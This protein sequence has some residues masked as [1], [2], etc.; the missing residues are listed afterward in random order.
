MAVLKWCQDT[1]IDWHYIAPRK[2]M[3]NAFVESFNG[4]FRD[5]LFERNPFLIAGRSPRENHRMEGRLQPH[6]TALIP[7]QPH[8]M[9]ICD[10]IET[11][12]QGRLM[13][14]INRRTLP[15]AG[16]TSGLRALRRIWARMLSKHTR[17]NFNR[18]L[19]CHA[20]ERYSLCMS[21]RNS[22][23]IAYLTSAYPAL[24]HTFVQREIAGLR[25]AG[26]KV[27]TASIRKTTGSHISGSVE[28]EEAKHTF[29]VLSAAPAKLF[30]S[31]LRAMIRPW[32]L[33]LAIA[34]AWRTRP[35]G[36]KAA[37]W[38][39]FYLLEAVILADHL[40]NQGVRHLHCHFANAGCSVA[41]LAGVLAEV[42]YSFTLHGP[43]TFFEPYKWR[44]DEKIARASF[45]VCISHFCRSQ[46]MI[47]AS[48]EHWEKMK[49][50]HCGV[51][52]ARYSNAV[53]PPGKML[54]FVGRLAA[55]KGVA[56]L[57][58][59]IAELTPRHPDL[60]L[61]LIGEGTEQESLE[62]LAQ[63]LG[64]TE[65]ITF[66]GP[67]T[68]SEV[69]EALAAS[70]VFVLPS[71]AEG[72]PVVLMEAMASR[73][74]VITTRIAGIPELVE[75]GVNGRLVPPGNISALAEAIEELLSAPD[76][77]TKM[78]QSG[79]SKVEAEFNAGIEAIKIGKLIDEVS[80]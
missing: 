9:A 42:P 55:V 74:P 39:M 3:Q 75:D 60:H 14:D 12:N 76:I 16:G 69:A 72:V 35:P 61:T 19:A 48:P 66:A 46:G 33:V 36:I 47:F 65:Q 22:E 71:F 20:V 34:L 32:L 58:R 4:S 41:M 17:T 44:L 64:I 59:A 53:R 11:G 80:K 21:N 29:Y 1:R 56:V 70:D 54:M 26:H 6:Q 79:R 10:E 50:V 68:Q 38:Q 43:D 49:I 2:T 27:L 45:V 67:K 40:R 52:P 5:A 51:D 18:I 77:R 57:L 73:Q 25:A 15:K 30:P 7:R 24:S 13:S 37:L 62:E 63:E 23:P 28:S 8:A 78:G 31:L